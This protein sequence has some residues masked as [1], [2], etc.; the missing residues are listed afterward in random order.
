MPLMKLC[1]TVAVPALIH[2]CKKWTLIKQNYRRT[3]MAELKFLTSVAGHMPVSA[4]CSHRANEEI[5]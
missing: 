1:K 5:R 4:L 3:E 2:G